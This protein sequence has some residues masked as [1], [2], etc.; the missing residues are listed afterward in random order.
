M[1]IGNEGVGSLEIVN[2]NAAEALGLPIVDATPLPAAEGEQAHNDILIVN[3]AESQATIEY[4]INGDRFVAKPGMKQRLSAGRSWSIEYDRGSGTARHHL[5][6]GTHHFRRTD[7]GWQLYRMNYD[8]VL[9]NS[10][11]NQEFHLVFR[12]RNICIP[13]GDSKTLTSDYPIVVRFDRG[14][15]SEFVA[16]HIPFVVGTVQ[17]AV[18]ATDNRWDLFDARTNGHATVDLKPFNAEGARKR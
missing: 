5:R 16:K 12:E 2:G 11:S 13:A 1:L 14:N 9:D 18:N 4:R 10:Q 15:D 3:P 17:I 6:P 7:E 8:I